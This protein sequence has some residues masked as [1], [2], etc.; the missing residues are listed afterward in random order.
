MMK[1]KVLLGMSGGIDSSVAAML[2][3][4]KGYE[5]IGLTL[6]THG[7][8]TEHGG[9]D[10]VKL[11]SDLGIEH[12]LADCRSDFKTHVIDYFT[13][14]Y[15]NGQT[16]N[17]CVRCNEVLKW[18]W[19]YEWSL[20]LACDLIATGHYVRQVIHHDQCYIQKGTDPA[21]D[22]S[23]FLWNLNQDLLQ[24]ATFPLGSL[25]KTEVKQ[26]AAK[27]GF[28]T[29]SKKKESMGVCFLQNSNYR[30]YLKQHLPSDH[31]ALQKG[32]VINLENEIIGEHEG[33]VNYTLGQ[34][35]HLDN[36]KRNHCVVKI[37]PEK[38]QIVVGPKD[39]LLKQT[40]QLSQFR[41]TTDKTLWQGQDIF[42]RIRGIDS[43]P[44]YHGR[45]LP[46]GENLT[47]W[48]NEPVWALTPGQSIVLYQN[49][50]VIGGGI[51]D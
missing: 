9:M 45:L 13:N 51:V 4:H 35:K 29:L 18:K 48:F 33:Y 32:S 20:K 17:P 19:L 36:I 40:I 41:L 21:K 12:H 28:P 3:L 6:V 2:L 37:I 34:K 10:A 39:Q 11:A 30:S 43:A 1:Q 5:V 15:I 44:G 46:E 27:F 49:D 7:S 25:T 16:P 26:L 8:E 24:K 23:Y 50:W 14:S 47:V 42:I 31:R 22:Q 38:N